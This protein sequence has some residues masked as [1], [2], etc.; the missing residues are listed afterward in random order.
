MVPT[1]ALAAA[2]FTAH[3]GEAVRVRSVPNVEASVTSAHTPIE[4]HEEST[5]LM[6]I[7]GEP[8]MLEAFVAHRV[9]LVMLAAPHRVMVMM[10]VFAP[11]TSA[12]ALVGRG[13]ARGY[14]AAE[15][16]ECRDQNCTAKF[17][18]LSPPELVGEQ[19]VHVLPRHVLTPRLSFFHRAATY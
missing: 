15:E 12:I 11:R 7:P 4:A 14:R 2:F 13:C 18:H 3:H 1:H 8:M 5:A 17:D 9:H 19:S 10:M 16:S 6:L